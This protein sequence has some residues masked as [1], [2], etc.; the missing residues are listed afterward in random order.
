MKHLAIS[1]Q[2]DIFQPQLSSERREG[3]IVALR[4]EHGVLYTEIEKLKR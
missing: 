2:N 1:L 3:K 4:L